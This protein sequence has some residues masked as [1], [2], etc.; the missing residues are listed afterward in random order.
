M[1]P[2]AISWKNLQYGWNETI[3]TG[4]QFTEQ[5][6][7]LDILYIYVYMQSSVMDYVFILYIIM[8]NM[9]T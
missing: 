6:G 9:K 7:I 5:Y 2:T 8:Y 4:Q 1:L 3:F